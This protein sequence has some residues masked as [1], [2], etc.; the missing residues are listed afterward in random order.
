MQKHKSPKEIQKLLSEFKSSSLNQ[1]EFCQK[2]SLVYVTF[3][4][5]RRK[6][7][8]QAVSLPTFVKTQPLI[9]KNQESEKFELVTRKFKLNI[10]QGFQCDDLKNLISALPC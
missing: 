1:R 8:Q 2:H 7:G 5:W 3:Q 9:T 10:P 4:S 6:W